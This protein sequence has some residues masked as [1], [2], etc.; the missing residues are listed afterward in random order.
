[1][2][3]HVAL[4]KKPISKGRFS[5]YL[6]FYPAIISD[7]TGRLTRREYLRLHIPVKPRTTFEKVQ[8]D[9]TLE[10]AEGIRNKRENELNKPEVYHSFEKERKN[11]EK[12][13]EK[14]FI[15]YYRTLCR[16]R[17]SSNHDNWAA[18]LLHLE[19]YTGGK[20]TFSQLTEQFCNG[21]K[22]HLMNA[23]RQ[24]SDTITLSQNSAVSYF[25]K[26]KAALKQAYRDG[27]IFDNLSMKVSSIKTLETQRNF[28]TLEE[29]RK[30]VNTNCPD[31]MLK[32]A[33]LF[34]ALTG[35]RF[36]DIQRLTWGDLEY[37]DGE[38]F[39]RFS[40]K[41]TKAP[42]YHPI[43]EQAVKLMGKPEDN[44]KQVFSGLRYSTA[45]SRDI[46]KWLG[47]AGITKDVTFHGFRHT[48]ATLQ[49][50][51]GTDIYTVSKLLGHKNL[52]TTQI[53]AKVMD[54]AK[55]D[56]ANKIKL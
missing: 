51:N 18:S 39:I 47:L 43:S 11:R 14:D 8:K 21:F 9:N 31:P 6:D 3:V 4:R 12:I 34:S 44:T 49:L 13:G 46:V 26:F 55:R 7:K 22:D 17:Q 30:L 25:N 42:E 24:G 40:Q 32:N 53:Y 37:N 2:G 33:A 28:L 48:Y 23:R 27:F 16:K 52:K 54:Q 5:L 36:S 45:T 35:L 10:I 38:Y 41:K 1:M 19:N 20:L 56:A 29:L 50:S 15:E